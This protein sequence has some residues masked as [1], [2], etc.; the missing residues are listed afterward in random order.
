MQHQHSCG[1]LESRIQIL[2]CTIQEF[3]I[4]VYSL[5][6]YPLLEPA[7]VHVKGV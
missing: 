2:G 1:T 3:Y 6:H 7:S 5:D 4:T